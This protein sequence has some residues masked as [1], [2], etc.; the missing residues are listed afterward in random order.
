MLG[1]RFLKDHKQWLLLNSLVVCHD[2][3]CNQTVMSGDI[4]PENKEDIDE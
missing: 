1:R 2:T 4:P 3:T